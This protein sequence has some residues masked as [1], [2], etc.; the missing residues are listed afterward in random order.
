MTNIIA[1][2]IKPEPTAIKEAFRFIVTVRRSVR[3]AVEI[4]DKMGDKASRY[5]RQARILKAQASPFNAARIKTLEGM[6]DEIRTDCQPLRD[7]LKRWGRLMAD[8][9]PAI[10]ACTTLAQRCEILNVNVVDRADLAEDDGLTEIIYLHGLEDSAACRKRDWK[11]GP[12]YQASATV[13]IDF[14][15]N[16]KEGQA[17]GDSLWE[18][19]GMFAGVPMYKQSPD[20]TMQ[21]QPPKLYAINGTGALQS[22]GIAI[23]GTDS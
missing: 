7:C 20:G 10:D 13:F 4:L 15:L 12:M 21:R 14:L 18:P 9:A 6:A 11:N 16:T 17:L 3:Q 5:R 1:L 8:S 23:A 2:P 22:A 19:G